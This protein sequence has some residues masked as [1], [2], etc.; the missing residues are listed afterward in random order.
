MGWR[1]S[2]TEWQDL[3]D[4]I[5]SKYCADH[6]SVTNT[7]DTTSITVPAGAGKWSG[8]AL[9][10]NGKIYGIPH[11]RNT[12]LIID[13]EKNTVEEI[14]ATGWVAN[15]DWYG[16]TLAANGKIYAIPAGSDGVLV[17]D[18]KSNGSFCPA[19]LQSAYLNKF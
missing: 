15:A 6:R 16:G 13:P 3:W 8:G 19:V 4:S 5:D 9:A 2:R 1:C 12:I 11:F 18:T 7:A 14:A 10:P 17:I